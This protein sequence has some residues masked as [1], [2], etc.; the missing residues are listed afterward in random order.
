LLH[1]LSPLSAWDSG[2]PVI[3]TDSGDQRNDILVA[4]GSTGIGCADPVF[5]SIQARVSEGYAWIEQQVCQLSADPPKYFD[6]Y[7]FE[8]LSKTN[9]TQEEENTKV[10]AISPAPTVAASNVAQPPAINNTSVTLP[11][12]PAGPYVLKNVSAFEASLQ[13]APFNGTVALATEGQQRMST[14]ASTVSFS[15]STRDSFGMDHFVV[16]ILMAMMVVLGILSTKNL[17]RRRRG[18]RSERSR[19]IDASQRS[20]YNAVRG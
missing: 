17:F 15:T 20:G 11:T 2:A 16:M 3:V 13:F 19:L 8:N 5:P 12:D 10:P 4:L 9:S 7:Q 1:A 14:I 6:C 18:R